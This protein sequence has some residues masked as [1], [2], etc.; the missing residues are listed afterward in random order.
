MDVANSCALILEKG[1]DLH[2]SSAVSQ[3]DIR[4]YHDELPTLAI[5]H[6]MVRIGIAT[7]LVA[8][9]LRIQLLPSISLHY[10]GMTV[11]LE[12]RTKGGLTGTRTAGALGRVPILDLIATREHT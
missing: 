12:K 6:F 3:A 9:S 1:C 5:C 8:L 7:S 2:G 11:N 4:S 10:A